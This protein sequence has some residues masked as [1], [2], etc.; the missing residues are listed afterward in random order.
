MRLY[1][2]SGRR[3]TYIEIRLFQNISE[4]A[5]QLCYRTRDRITYRGHIISITLTRSKRQRNISPDKFGLIRRG[6]IVYS[7]RRWM[8]HAHALETGACTSA[9]DNE[10]SFLFACR[11]ILCGYQAA[12][13]AVSQT[14]RRGPRTRVAGRWSMI[15]SVYT[16]M[17]RARSVTG[18]A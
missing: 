6:V 18:P 12:K 13:A 3:C 11:H 7:L 16:C 15:L 8:T 2:H 14:Q 5:R 9:R 10:L 17:C 1:C 4:S